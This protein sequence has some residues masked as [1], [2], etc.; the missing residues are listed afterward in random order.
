MATADHDQGFKAQTG[1][2]HV[3][4]TTDERADLAV[5]GE[6]S[7]VHT[8]TTPFSE[9]VAALV[10]SAKGE[11]RGRGGCRSGARFLATTPALSRG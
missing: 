2:E 11:G 6:C 3:E 7:M 1:D 9:F 4:R 8:Y 10:V 5:P